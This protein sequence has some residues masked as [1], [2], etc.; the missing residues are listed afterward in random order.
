MV[1]YINIF[2]TS[3]PICGQQPWVAVRALLIDNYTKILGN[4]TVD[5]KKICKE[6]Q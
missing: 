6:F 3:H 2:C 5:M 1:Y 4:N